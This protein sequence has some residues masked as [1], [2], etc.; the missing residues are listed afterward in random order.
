MGKTIYHAKEDPTYKTVYV[1]IERWE[2]RLNPNDKDGGNVKYFFVHGGFKDEAQD[3]DIKFSFCFPE[4]EA[5][6]GHFFHYLC[7]F[8]GPDEEMASFKRTGSDDHIAFALING[9]YFI[10]T[11]M[12]SKAAFGPAAD[13]TLTWKSSAMCAEYSREYAM[14]FYG[15]ARPYGYVYGGSGG[16]YKSMA[17]IENTDA[18]DGAA[19]FVIGSPVSLPNSISLHVYGQR[20][21]RH[22]FRNIVDALDA[23]G[24]GDPE[25]F[26]DDLEK[27]GYREVC[28]MGFPPKA[29][30]VEAE[31]TVDPGSL[32]VLTPGVKAADPTYFTDF[33]TVPGYEGADPES[34]SCRDRIVFDGV[35]K[36]VHLPDQEAEDDE[37][38]NG[39]DTAWKK[40][41]ASGNGAW[42][43]LEEVPQKEDPYLEGLDLTI[44]SGK[45]EGKVM[46]LQTIIG[47]ALVIGS[48][49]GFSDIGDVINDIQP[50][51][52][53]HL[54]NSDYIAIQLYYRHQIPDD[55][56]FTVFKRFRDA[57]GKLS[58]PQ[59]GFIMSYGFNGTGTIQD[60]NIQGKVIMNQSLMD[61]S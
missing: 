3:R 33:W 14:K 58:I 51:D 13:Q 1:D 11:N 25:E 5:Y 31:G 28:R 9:A 50:G 35:V 30:F 29:W 20:M 18:W 8:P 15:C 43:E 12:G 23:G 19:P 59:R 6:K 10:E 42:I 17:C 26:M 53:V 60:G 40:S 46:R 38:S 37:Y 39:V 24:S 47:N 7:P 49:F 54:D 34:D 36:A 52:T 44:T 16:G 41:L 22:Q 48:A 27:E 56:S 45:A 57:D 55:P 61:E 32:P 2:E 21:L 4:K